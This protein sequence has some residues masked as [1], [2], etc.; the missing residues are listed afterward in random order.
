MAGLLSGT[1]STRKPW[2][3]GRE[4][5]L[6]NR[7]A[8]W[9]GSSAS[10]SFTSALPLTFAKAPDHPSAPSPSW[11]TGE[12]ECSRLPGWRFQTQAPEIVIDHFDAR[13]KLHWRCTGATTAGLRT[14]RTNDPLDTPRNYYLLA[15]CHP[16]KSHPNGCVPETTSRRPFRTLGDTRKEDRHG[17]PPIGDPP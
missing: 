9:I 15:A 4:P 6:G 13:W 3:P 11:T 2:S 14:S 1:E 8:I 7:F 12:V 5:M 17:L 16:G 10:R